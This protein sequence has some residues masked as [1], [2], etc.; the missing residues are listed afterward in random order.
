MALPD[1]PKPVS[2]PRGAAAANERD[3]DEGEDKGE[4]GKAESS[5]LKAT[6]KGGKRAV[7][8]LGAESKDYK[9]QPNPF[10]LTEQEKEEALDRANARP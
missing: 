2:Q 10:L 3:D 8:R 5:A 7:T 1:L 9:D 6:R 4:D